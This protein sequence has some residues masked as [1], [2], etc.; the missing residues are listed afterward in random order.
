MRDEVVALLSA[1]GLLIAVLWTVDLNPLSHDISACQAG[2]AVSHSALVS[3]R[4]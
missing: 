2:C 3:D 4:R 1:L